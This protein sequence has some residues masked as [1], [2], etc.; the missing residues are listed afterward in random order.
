MVFIVWFFFV[1]FLVSPAFKEEVMWS[2][3]VISNLCKTRGTQESKQRSTRN[4]E[5]FENLVGACGTTKKLITCI[6]RFLDHHI[7]TARN[8]SCRKVMFSQA[9]VSHSVHQGVGIPGTWSL[10]GGGYACFHVPF[11]GVDMSRGRVGMCIGLES[12]A[13]GGG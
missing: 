7:I 10:P 13:G 11:R 5:S 12:G 3:Q 1:L 8:S 2:R 4:Q 9:S 6:C